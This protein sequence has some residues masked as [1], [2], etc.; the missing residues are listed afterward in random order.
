MF[1]PSRIEYRQY[2]EGARNNN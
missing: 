1:Q 2:T